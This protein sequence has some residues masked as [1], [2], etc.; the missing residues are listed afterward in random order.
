[1]KKLHFENT[2]EFETLFKNKKVEITN[3]IVNGIEKAMQKNKKSA[4]LFEITFEDAD[5][6]FEISLPKSQWKQALDEC[7]K[8]YHRL[9]MSDEAI[10]CWKLLELTKVW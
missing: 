10:D 4:L 9:E 2:N 1:M 7:L 3:A 8:H 6:M 5:T